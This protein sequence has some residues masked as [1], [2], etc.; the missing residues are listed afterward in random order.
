MP[1]AR[2]WPPT[3]CWTFSWQQ[4]EPQSSKLYVYIYTSCILMHICMCIYICIYTYLYMS[5]YK[6]IIYTYR[7][8][9]IYIYTYILLWIKPRAVAGPRPPLCYAPLSRP[10]VSNPL[11]RILRGYDSTYYLKVALCRGG[12]CHKTPPSVTKRCREM[13]AQACYKP[14]VFD[15]LP[16][17]HASISHNDQQC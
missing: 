13:A 3:S 7:Y 16:Y 2:L 6:H 5:L 4:P 11:S 14:H 17:K 12:G 8:T 10:A 9:Y 15:S 1:G